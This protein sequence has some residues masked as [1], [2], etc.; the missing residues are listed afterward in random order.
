MSIKILYVVQNDT[1]YK[2]FKSL[3]K[4]GDAVVDLSSLIGSEPYCYPDFVEVFKPSISANYYRLNS[5]ERV[6][7]ILRLKESIRAIT[8]QIVVEKVVIG[9]D[10][11]M[12]RLIISMLNQNHSV[13]VEMWLDGL[14]SFRS[15]RLTLLGKYWLGRLFES[16]GVP[17]LAPSVIGTYSR[18][19]KLFVMHESVVQEY[20]ELFK[21]VAKKCEVRV[22]PRHEELLRTASE[23]RVNDDVKN[24]R[25]MTS[26]WLFHG[27]LKADN[28]QR[29]QVETL[30]KYF[31][32]RSDYKFILRVH[33]RDDIDSYLEIDGLHIESANVTFEQSLVSSDVVMSARSTALM[34]GQLLGKRVILYDQYF[35]GF[36]LTGYLSSLP[37]VNDVTELDQL[38][39]CYIND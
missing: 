36:S 14:I 38:L 12:Q 8:K 29:R 17:F 34:E 7:F 35:D 24:V 31:S 11:A 26:A 27:H 15:K 4:K 3:A 10:G 25:Y 19:E 30:Y 39:R 20:S 16:F 9:N 32:L 22:F 21:A 2:N 37:R 6:A 28:W 1:H 13:Q 33:P 5:L 18:I 23:D